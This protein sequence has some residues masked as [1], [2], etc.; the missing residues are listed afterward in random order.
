MDLKL[1]GDYDG[2]LI[3]AIKKRAKF[4]FEPLIKVID[5]LYSHNPSF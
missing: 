3:V 4:S 2:M 5:I 1:D